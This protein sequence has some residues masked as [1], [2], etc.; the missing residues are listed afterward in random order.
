[1]T[2]TNPINNPGTG[3]GSGGTGGG[4]GG[5]TNDGG[6]SD[7]NCVGTYNLCASIGSAIECTKACTYTGTSGPQPDPTDC[8]NPPTLGTCTP[9]G[10]C[11]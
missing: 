5:T 11:Q 2:C 4:S 10:F 7:P 9:R 3:S 6:G 8:P 1:V